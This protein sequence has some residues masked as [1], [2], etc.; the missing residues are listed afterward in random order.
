MSAM[1]ATGNGWY[2]AWVDFHRKAT[3]ANAEAVAAL[4]A[5]V[6][7]AVEVW[8]ATS[9]ELH[10]CTKRLVAARRTPKFANEHADSVGTELVTLRKERE[11]AGFM[12]PVSIA[13][14]SCPMQCDKGLLFAPL[15]HLVRVGVSGKGLLRTCAVL[16]D[17]CAYGRAE[18]ELQD[19]LE[20]QAAPVKEEAWKKKK[21]VTLTKYFERTGGIDGISMLRDYEA[22][23]IA[24]LNAARTD[25]DTK[26]IPTMK[27][28][29]GKSL[30]VPFKERPRGPESIYEGEI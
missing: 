12:V 7:I 26:S 2:Y 27:A 19:R 3:A 6:E 22:N 21:L 1:P 30:R 25:A 11:R 29:L 4:I 10:E 16:C 24:V 8:E 18:I 9:D 5:A 17:Q 20:K 28:M 23:C 13:P 15:P 14:G